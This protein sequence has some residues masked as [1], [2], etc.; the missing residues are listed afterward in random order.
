M[1]PARVSRARRWTGL[2][3][4]L[5]LALG[6]AA[7]AG[8][9]GSVQGCVRPREARQATATPGGIPVVEVLV[10]ETSSARGIVE[11]DWG[12]LATIHIQFTPVLYQ[13]TG[14]ARS[15]SEWQDHRVTEMQ[16]CTGLVTPCE[17]SGEWVPFREEQQIS[18]PVD[19]LGS[20]K[21][22]V[23]AQFRDAQG[24][25]VPAIDPARDE[26]EGTLRTF[27]EIVGVVN[28]ATPVSLQPASIQTAI[29]ATEVA[30]PVKGSVE[31][32]GGICC[33]GG[34]AGEAIDLRV[35]FRAESPYGPI[36]AMRVVGGSLFCPAA[37]KMESVPWEPFVAEKIYSATL[38]INWVG[39]FVA[40]QYRD[41]EGHLSPV[42]CD[43]ISLEGSPP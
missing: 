30:F 17:L 16:L 28:A 38:T 11:R 22:W 9:L 24:H 40:V 15:F 27:Q 5:A 23:V 10:Y 43:D 35:A 21:V 4:I 29:A 18:V 39:W 1:R 3:A 13:R 19:W 26:P 32:E 14:S 33:A 20:R 31:I 6:L 2:A 25:A 37:E 36:V 8:V 41:E 34:K 7:M 12:T 42:Y